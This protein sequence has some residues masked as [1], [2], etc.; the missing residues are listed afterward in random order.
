MLDDPNGRADYCKSG[1]GA[2]SILFTVGT[3]ADSEF[4]SWVDDAMAGN[5]FEVDI[6]KIYPKTSSMTTQT[7]SYNGS[8]SEPN[9]TL[10]FC[11]Y[12]SYPSMSITQETLDKLKV[13]DVA[14]NNRAENLGA[15]SA[16]IQ[17]YNNGLFYTAPT[18]AEANPE[19]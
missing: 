6:S 19:L 5:D 16:A 18:S 8:D 10:D 11:W 2:L 15:T 9:C 12:I 17:W 3:D 7:W 14:M 1:K 13:T 4:F